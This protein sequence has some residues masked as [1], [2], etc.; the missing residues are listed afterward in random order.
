[1]LLRWVWHFCPMRLSH[2][3]IYCRIVFITP[4]GKKR[5]WKIKVFTVVILCKSSVKILFSVSLLSSTHQYYTKWTSKRKNEM[6]AQHLP[7]YVVATCEYLKPR[8][9]LHKGY[10]L[11]ELTDPCWFTLTLWYK[12]L[13]EVIL[14]N[15]KTELEFSLDTG[16]SSSFIIQSMNNFL[17]C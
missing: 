11:V 5:K 3:T 6:I 9:M 17:K 12:G 1:M 15:Q 7:P 2:F 8:L 10:F 4:L 13:S 16:E 14:L